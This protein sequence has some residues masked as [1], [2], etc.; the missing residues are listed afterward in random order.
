M[1][2]EQCRQG[3]PKPGAAASSLRVKLLHPVPKGSALSEIIWTVNIVSKIHSA[4]AN[5]FA[6][7][8]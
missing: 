5:G 1:E 7:F 6:L 2:A 3:H 4:L 8:L